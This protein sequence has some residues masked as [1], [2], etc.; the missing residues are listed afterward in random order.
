MN[1]FYSATVLGFPVYVILWFFVI[2]SFLGVLV[3]MIFCLVQESVPES[4]TGLL[5][6]PLRRSTASAAWHARC[7][8][9]GGPSM[10]DDLSAPEW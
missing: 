7:S 1:A 5:Y 2:Y 4:R 8:C 9:T 3:E 10:S 6:V